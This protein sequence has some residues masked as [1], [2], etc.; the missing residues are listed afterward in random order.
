MAKWACPTWVWAGKDGDKDDPA[1]DL[2]FLKEDGE[3]WDRWIMRGRMLKPSQAAKLDRPVLPYDLRHTFA[4]M[5]TRKGVH[6]ATLQKMMG[7]SNIEMTMRYVHANEA[8]VQSAVEMM[9]E[10]NCAGKG[11]T[12]AQRTAKNGTGQAHLTGIS[13]PPGLE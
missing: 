8:M 1:D 13:A 12:A 11:G 9:D 7:H 2:V 6:P 10:D 5:A 4:T 3:E